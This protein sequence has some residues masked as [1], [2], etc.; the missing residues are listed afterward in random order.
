M[1]HGQIYNNGRDRISRRFME[2]FCRFHPILIIIFSIETKIFYYF[3][4]IISSWVEQR[5]GYLFESDWFIRRKQTSK[6]LIC[7]TYVR[8]ACCHNIDK[9]RKRTTTN[10]IVDI[11][12]IKKSCEKR[13]QKTF[14]CFQTL[15][16]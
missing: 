5:R 14:Y 10:V 6:L 11:L 2:R 16:R 3:I 15:P 13:E 8:S 4:S 12:V 7:V 9:K 1:T